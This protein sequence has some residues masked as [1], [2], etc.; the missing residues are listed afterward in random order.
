MRNKSA[1]D[2]ESKTI[3]HKCSTI[4]EIIQCC[5]HNIF[6]GSEKGKKLLSIAIEDSLQVIQRYRTAFLENLPSEADIVL[7]RSFVKML[8]HCS[9]GL[10][11]D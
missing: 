4:Y 6:S 9:G 10:S 3:A 2:E 7:I 8:S 1:I 11:S 5:I